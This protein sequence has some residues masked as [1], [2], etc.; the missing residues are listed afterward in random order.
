MRKPANAFSFWFSCFGAKPQKGGAAYLRRVFP[1]GDR[2]GA[3]VTMWRK[4]LQR[5][6]SGKSYKGPR[7]EAIERSRWELTH[8]CSE[9]RREPQ[10]YLPCGTHGL[11]E[12]RRSPLWLRDAPRSLP[13]API[14]PYTP[15][16]GY[17]QT[18]RRTQEAIFG[19]PATRVL[20]SLSAHTGTLRNSEGSVRH[21]ILWARGV[22]LVFARTAALRVASILF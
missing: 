1:G 7:K 9:S 18:V 14:D 19:P 20:R 6:T 5:R 8:T 16:G 2:D 22:R 17:F 11:F 21:R 12:I 13:R 15:R 4:S 3:K 10:I